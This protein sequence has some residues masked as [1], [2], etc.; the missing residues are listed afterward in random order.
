MSNYALKYTGAVVVLLLVAA[1]IGMLIGALHLVFPWGLLLAA[2][3]GYI[4]NSVWVK[5]ILRPMRLQHEEEA[6]FRG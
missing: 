2:T 3:V 1:I 4:L 6:R 5:Y